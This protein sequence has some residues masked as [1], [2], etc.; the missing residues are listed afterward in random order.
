M[1]ELLEIYARL[2]LLSVLWWV[3]AI[4][5]VAVLRILWLEFWGE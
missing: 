1:I 3:V 2:F 4:L 5:V